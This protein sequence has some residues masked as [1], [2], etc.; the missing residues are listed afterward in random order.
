M[1]LF[2]KWLYLTGVRMESLGPAGG[3]MDCSSV[4]MILTSSVHSSEVMGRQSLPWLVQKGRLPAHSGVAAATCDLPWARLT[5]RGQHRSPGNGQ[6]WDG[7]FC[8]RSWEG[9]HPDNHTNE[10]EW[11]SPSWAS[12]Q[13]LSPNKP[14]D[15]NLVWHLKP[16][17][18]T[19]LY[20]IPDQL[21]ESKCFLFEAAKCW[22]LVNVAVYY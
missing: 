17:N 11:N 18:P 9:L 15:R 16:E 2:K 19:Q 14:L 12:R 13:D 5:H 22:D 4:S 6:R 10:P 7:V 3:Q 20:C 21:I 8:P 1:R